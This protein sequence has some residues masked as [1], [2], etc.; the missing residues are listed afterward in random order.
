MQLGILWTVAMIVFVAIECIS[1]QL[2]SIWMAAGSLAALVAY[3]LGA[4]FITQ[5]LIFIAVSIILIIA[6]RP[7]SKK[8]INS[9][10]VSTNVDSIPG[11]VGV[12]VKEIDNLK[13][14]GTV[15][16]DGMEWSARSVDE[17]IIL[18]GETVK[19]LEVR[20]VKVIVERR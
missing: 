19:V 1:Y 8:I 3:F 13:N 16:I 14:T 4:E 15:I 7:L 2:M 11:K 18:E 10:S 5:F 20:G 9:K 17:S 6:T 12:A